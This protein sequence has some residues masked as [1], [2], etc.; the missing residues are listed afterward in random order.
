M[1]CCPRILRTSVEALNF[2]IPHDDIID[3][4]YREET[5]GLKETDITGGIY[6]LLNLQQNRTLPFHLGGLCC[7]ELPEGRRRVKESFV[8]REDAC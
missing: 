8:S 6:F 1:W 4:L 3:V 5:S 7:Q 2:T